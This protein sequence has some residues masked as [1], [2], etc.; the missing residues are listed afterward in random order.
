TGVQQAYRLAGGAG[1]LLLYGLLPKAGVA[2]ERSGHLQHSQMFG[3]VRADFT[4]D[5]RESDYQY[6]E[7]SGVST[8]TVGAGVNLSRQ[9]EG[10]NTTLTLREAQTTGSGR[11]STLTSSLNHTQQFGHGLSGIFGADYLTSSSSGAAGNSQVNSRIELRDHQKLFDLALQANDSTILSGSS[12][13]ASTGLQRQPELSLQPDTARFTG[14]FFG[15]TLPIQLL[16]S[17]G[18]FHEEPRTVE[19]ERALLQLD[20]RQ[21]I[22]EK[23]SHSLTLT[24]MFRQ[25]FYGDGGAQYVFGGTN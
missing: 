4:R 19:T 21:R 18:R 25:S 14:R 22:F 23:G 1:T 24:D 17:F 20:I 6:A 7:A 3:N 12:T 16:L 10:M 8:T 9:V 5:F 11:F 13:R 2:A 15:R